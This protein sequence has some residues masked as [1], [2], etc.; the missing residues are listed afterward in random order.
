VSDFDRELIELITDVDGEVWVLRELVG[1]RGA[2]LVS[3]VV[4]DGFAEV[5]QATD[6]ELFGRR[7][8]EAKLDPRRR[9]LTTEEALGAIRGD[10]MPAD[11]RVAQARG[12]VDLQAEPTLVFGYAADDPAAIVEVR[13]RNEEGRERWLQERRTLV[14]RIRK[15]A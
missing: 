10:R 9:Y 2:A 15:R 11:Y 13:R 3:R 7:S 6:E 8:L 4:A 1:L 12:A 14:R 5:F